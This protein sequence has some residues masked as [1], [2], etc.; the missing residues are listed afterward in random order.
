V[1]VIAAVSKIKI[2]KYKLNINEALSNTEHCINI[3]NFNYT[4]NI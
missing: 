2:K 1:Y 4:H 3:K